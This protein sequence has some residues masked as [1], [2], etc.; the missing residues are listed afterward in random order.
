VQYGHDATDALRAYETTATWIEDEMYTDI[1]DNLWFLDFGQMGVPVTSGYR[2]AGPSVPLDFSGFP[3]GNWTFWR[4]LTEKYPDAQA[5]LPTL[6]RSLWE[7]LD[8]TNGAPDRYSLEALNDTLAGLGTST[9]QEYAGF[10][11]ANRT[12]AQ[13]YSEGDSYPTPALAFEPVTLSA[14]QPAASQTMTLDHLTSGTS[15]FRPSGSGFT[16]LEVQVQM[17]PV[18]AGAAAI[19]LVVRKNGELA[20]VPVALDDGGSGQVEVPFDQGTI[21]R[22]EVTLANGSSAMDCGTDLSYPPRYSC[23]GLGVDDGMSAT[24]TVQAVS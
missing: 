2:G 15:A 16:Q 23:A 24:V 13:S 10:S 19:V 14:E 6:V 1:N 7:D 9:A 22:V 17:A 21:D 4:Y 20:R 11:S 3:Y 12:P 5:G 8:T 18:S